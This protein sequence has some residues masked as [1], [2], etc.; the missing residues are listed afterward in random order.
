MEKSLESL[1]F[2]PHS[3][4]EIKIENEGGEGAPKELVAVATSKLTGKEWNGLIL[5][6]QIETQVLEG[7]FTLILF[8]FILF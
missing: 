4:A 1:A 2:C 5:F 8:Y 6:L 3:P 7:N